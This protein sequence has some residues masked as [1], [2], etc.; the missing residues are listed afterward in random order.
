MQCRRSRAFS[1]TSSS[2]VEVQVSKPPEV[3]NEQP[4][5]DSTPGPSDGLMEETNSL[6]PVL[7]MDMMTVSNTGS[8]TTLTNLPSQHGSPT[9]DDKSVRKDP[10]WRMPSHVA[11]LAPEMQNLLMGFDPG[12]LPL[13]PRVIKLY[14]A[15]DDTGEDSLHSG[16][17]S[18][19][20]ELFLWANFYA[21]DRDT[22]ARA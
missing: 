22:C 11:S 3:Q 5:P 8:S 9:A 16:H 18:E 15:A 1:M 13:S 17:F 4:T 20:V 7:S 21:K 14:I 10:Q 6:I 12:P 19:L 2:E